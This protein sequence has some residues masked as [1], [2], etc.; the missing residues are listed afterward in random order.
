MLQQ[1]IIGLPV[2]LKR[3]ALDG[4]SVSTF[5]RQISQCW[6]SITAATAREF[7]APPRIWPR[8]G[9]AGETTS[10][11]TRSTCCARCVDRRKPRL[12]TTATRDWVRCRSSWNPSP[13]NVETVETCV[14]GCSLKED[15]VFLVFLLLSFSDT[16]L[17][18]LSGAFSPRE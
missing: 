1:L 3:L 15:V 11:M 2:S 16:E 18:D 13:C 4:T 10:T 8:S 7:A 9:P 12:K 5:L 6:I 14:V 17:L